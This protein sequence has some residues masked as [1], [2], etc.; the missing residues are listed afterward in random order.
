MNV[1][2]LLKKTIAHAVDLLLKIN[3]N[4]QVKLKVY[5]ETLI[6]KC[7][8]LWKDKY[9]FL[10]A[11]SDTDGLTDKC[12]DP[13]FCDRNAKCSNNLN[14]YSCTCNDGYTGSGFECSGL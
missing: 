8:Y 4:V 14:S 5:N 3:F 11:G 10:F 2:I 6:I 1:Q 7:L 13:S 12:K 9:L